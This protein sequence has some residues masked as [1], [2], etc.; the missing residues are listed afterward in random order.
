MP[1]MQSEATAAVAGA[2]PARTIGLVSAAH[3]Q[4]H[5]YMLLLPPLF[6]VL[7]QELGV[8]FVELGFAMT[9]FSAVSGLA[10]IPIG[11]LVDR[12]GARAIL[13]GGMLLQSAALGGI[14]LTASYG[15]LLPLICLLGLGNAVYHPADYAILSESVREETMGRAFSVHT[16]AGFTG[17]ALAPLSVITAS[18]AIGWGPALMTFAV[19]GSVL[20][21]VLGL[22]S[23]ALGDSTAQRSRHPDARPARAAL[24]LLF[25]GPILTGMMFF[26]GLAMYTSGVQDFGIS[27]LHGSYG[28]SLTEAGTIVSA[29]LFASPIG[30]LLGGSLADRTRRHDLIAFALTAA[31]AFLLFAA[32]VQQ[33]APAANVALFAVAGLLTGMVA[34]S[35]DMLIRALAPSGDTG[36]VFG[37]V[38]SGVLVGG[39]I[40]PLVYG[41]LL[42]RAAGGLVFGCAAA[43]ALA[44]AGTALV[45]SS[46]TRP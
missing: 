41:F 18:S 26:A 39:V 29:F 37:F 38:T 8:D 25:S 12:Y 30:V 40:G 11:Y 23:A 5:F 20:A 19:A 7:R 46:R 32:A 13:I 35:R 36:K 6:P 22:N 21:V 17:G 14:G 15:A 34:P 10:Q 27:V 42:D 24:E 9:L 2:R 45:C 1:S 43:V 4:S 16:F 31:V 44:T 28:A 33:L 3:F